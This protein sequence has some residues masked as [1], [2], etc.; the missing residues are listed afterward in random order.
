MLLFTPLSKTST[1]SPSQQP[2]TGQPSTQV[3]RLTLPVNSSR[4]L[5]DVVTHSLPATLS[6]SKSI[7]QFLRYLP[8][9]VH[10]LVFMPS[11]TSSLL[12]QHLEAV[13]SK[14]ALQYRGRCVCTITIL[15]Y[16]LT[17]CITWIYIYYDTIIF[18]IIY[19]YIDFSS[20]WLPRII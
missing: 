6:Y 15:L 18:I 19:Y 12:H 4:L 17:T 7:H 11:D 1:L 20:S 8:C 14:L 13:S 2:D 16:I 5:R 10:V 3:T 9:R